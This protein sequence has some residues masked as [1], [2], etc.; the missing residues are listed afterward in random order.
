MNSTD[1]TADLDGKKCVKCENNAKFT[2][3]D[4]KKAWYCQE[5]FIQMDADARETLI[6]YDGSASGAFLLNQI[7]D[8]LKQ[9]TYK[10]LMVQPTVLV[11]VSVTEETEIQRV[12]ERVEELKK[13]LLE[14]VRWFIAHV[15]CSMYTDSVDLDDV[16]CNGTEKIPEYTDLLSSCSVPTYRKELERILREKCLQNISKSLKIS[17]CMVPD[18]ADDLGRLA[19]DQLCLGRGGSLSPLVTVTDKR[20]DF[21]LIRPIC[22]LSKREI[23]IYNYLCAIDKQYIQ[24]HNHSNTLD[25]SVQALTDAFIRTLEDEKFYSTI[26]TVLSTASKIHNTNGKDG[27]RCVLCH[28][29]VADCSLCSTCSAIRDS[30][31]DLLSRFL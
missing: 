4:P 24:F 25:R 11:L 17:K 15:A 5:C 29:E 3:V 14:N 22:D 23:S 8:A 9:I 18:D 28:V 6:V 12:V 30:C 10:R 19:L 20:S 13:E 1:F 21:L 7:D 26:N 27:S 2:G 16:R 31:S